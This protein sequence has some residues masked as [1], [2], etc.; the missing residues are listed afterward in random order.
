MGFIYKD[1]NFSKVEG[2][3]AIDSYKVS[4]S[5]GRGTFKS[6]HFTDAAGF[7]SLARDKQVKVKG[8]YSVNL[9]DIPYM[10]DVGAVKF[11]HGTTQGD[12][13]A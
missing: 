7:V 13:G 11:K 9:R 3:L 8:N 12:H 10:L 1:M 2:L 4:I 5:K 6:S